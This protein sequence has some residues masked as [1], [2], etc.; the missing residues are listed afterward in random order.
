ML[1]K[2]GGNNRVRIGSIKPQGPAAKAGLQIND[3][4]I[5]VDGT[6]FN[7]NDTK[8]SPDDVAKVIRDSSGTIIRVIVER[9]GKKDGFYYETKTQF[10]S[11]YQVG[12]HA[13][14]KESSMY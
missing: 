12:A 3:I 5:E 9:E 11:G 7:N 6:N 2:T 14:H 1:I 8:K 13:K 4:I 10:G